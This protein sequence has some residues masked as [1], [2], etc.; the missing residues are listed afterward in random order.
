VTVTR[1]NGLRVYTTYITGSLSKCA[2][3]LT[4]Y[5]FW[6]YR[7][8]RGRLRCRIAKVLRV[9]PRQKCAQHA[10]LTGGLWT[11]YFA[12][13][14]CGALLEQR[15]ALIALAAPLVILITATLIDIKWPVAAADDPQGTA[16]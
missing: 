13:A 7:R 6:F 2:E 10:A 4:D 8:T 12:G 3:A 9:T 14:V 1:I 11:F 15:F 5:I 16:G